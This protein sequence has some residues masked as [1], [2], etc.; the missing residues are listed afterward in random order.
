MHRVVAVA[1]V[2]LGAATVA[3][4]GIQLTGAQGDS[5]PVAMEVLTRHTLTAAE[6]KEGVVTR[7][8]FAPGASMA[9][10]ESI[11]HPGEEFVYILEGAAIME[12][13]GEEPIRFEQGD[14]WY[15]RLQQPHTLS[16]A[17]SSEPLTVLG[18]FIA[19]EG[20]F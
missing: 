2:V 16:N 9:G 13:E 10:G 15:N 6:G 5:P 3:L 11:E 12:R 14:S 18:I 17:S 7:A 8:R 4:L 19:E 20:A 1:A